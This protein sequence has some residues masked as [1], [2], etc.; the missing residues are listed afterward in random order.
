MV[1]LIRTTTAQKKK[2]RSKRTRN[3]LVA[4]ALRLLIFELERCIRR[5]QLNIIIMRYS[6][7]V[8]DAFEDSER[9]RICS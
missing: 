7:S 8:C 5:V 6:A 1:Y 2:R 4:L 3:R 9:W